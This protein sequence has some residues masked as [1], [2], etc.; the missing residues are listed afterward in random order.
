MADRWRPAWGAAGFAFVVS[1]FVALGGAWLGAWQLISSDPTRTRG[2]IVEGAMMWDA[3]WYWRVAM[4]GYYPW[5]KD[6]GSDLA[7][8]PLFP[9][10]VRGVTK[11]LTLLNLHI[12]DPL[13]GNFVLAG[14]LISNACF[15]AALVLLWQL[16]RQD[17]PAPVADRTLLLI[18][19]FPA[20]LFWSAIYTESLFFLLVVGTFWAARQGRWPLAAGLAGLAGVTRWAGLLLGVVILLEYLGRDPAAP[21]WRARVRAIRPDGLWLALVPVPFLAFL[22]YLQLAFGNAWIFLDAEQQGW[23]H[24]ASVFPLVWLDGLGLLIASW[25]TTSPATDPVLHWGGGQRFYMYQDLA[26]TALFAG[27][28]VWAGLR[29]LLRPSELAWLSLGVI[30]P[31]SLGTT[32]AMTRYLLPL[33]PAFLLLARALEPR[34]RLAQGWLVMSTGLL[35]ITAFFWAHGNWVG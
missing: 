7:F 5:S 18:G 25:T 23:R 12:G 14:L 8:C 22:T 28:A 32:L 1:R 31:L 17:Y 34:P 35:A 6:L 9:L 16:I 15:L 20:G 26:L 19:V 21:G 10:L 30:F 3:A 29:R 4:Q 13:Y 2:V 24:S 33:W 11:T 27:L